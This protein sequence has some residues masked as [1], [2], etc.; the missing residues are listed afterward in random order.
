[1]SMILLK[2]LILAHR[3]DRIEGFLLI[4]KISVER[5]GNVWLSRQ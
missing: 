5:V 1:M 3:I 4:N 2:S